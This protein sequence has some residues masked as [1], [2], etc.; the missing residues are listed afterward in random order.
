VL[1]IVF[2]YLFLVGVG[3]L[4]SGIAALGRDLQE[5]LFSRVSNPIAG[6]CV[7]ILATVL[8]Q[9]SSVST[10]TIVGLVGAGLLG[11]DEAVPMI[12]GANIGTTVTNTLASLGHIRQTKDFERAFAAATVHDFF[13]IIAVAIL[14]PLEITTKVIS[15]LAESLSELL[16]GGA[17][18]TYESPIR[19]WVKTP[20]RWID[21]FLEGLGV[22]GNWLG[23]LLI[24]MALALI[25]VSLNQ[26]TANMRK[27]IASRLE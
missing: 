3:L 26:I 10:A 5:Q 20:V 1:A 23:L 27:V 17:G 24:V 13:N 6:L 12:M 15:R 11:V 8:V 21:D 4:E 18:A 22:S 2:L 14:L 25:F 9:S 16:I 7:G 19:A